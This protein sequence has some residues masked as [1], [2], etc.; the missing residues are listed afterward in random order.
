M[1]PFS[2]TA[3]LSSLFSSPMFWASLGSQAVGTMLNSSARDDMVQR[4]NNLAS[5]ERMR[6]QQIDQE[7]QAALNATL[8]KFTAESQKAQQSELAD[9]LT[10]YLSPQSRVSQESEYLPGNPSAPKE[11]QDSLANRLADSL[12]K[13]QAYAK[14]L[15]NVSSF[16]R[17]GFDNAALLNR[18]GEKVG[19]LNSASAASSA[20][21]PYEMAAP[22]ASSMRKGGLADMFNGA[23]QIGMLASITGAGKVARPMQVAGDGLWV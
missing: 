14:N 21:L 10:Q 22:N 4:N 1:E 16:G 8:P 13:G 11:V 18:T 3:A 15:A 19:Q 5:M 20:L 6:Q 17:V 12:K 23:G 9:K 7:R 2:L